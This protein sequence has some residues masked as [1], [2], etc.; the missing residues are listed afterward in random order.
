MTH[1]ILPESYRIT[2]NHICE[3]KKLGSL[4]MSVAALF[5]GKWG[6][7]SQ[8]TQEKQPAASVPPTHE[9]DEDEDDSKAGFSRESNRRNSRFYRSMRKKRLASSEQ[10]ESKTTSGLC[11]TFKLTSCT[12]TI[13]LFAHVQLKA[14]SILTSL[15]NTTIQQH[16]WK[17]SSA[18]VMEPLYIIY[19]ALCYFVVLLTVD[20]V[21]FKSGT[22]AW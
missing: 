3:Q 22:K 12:E 9:E 6:H 4:T 2:L 11:Q 1:F 21:V 18:L 20:A 10:S 8:E 15:E 16:G 19:S 5:R 17:F 13:V 7:K 14:L